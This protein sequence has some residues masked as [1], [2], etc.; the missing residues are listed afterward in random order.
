[1]NRHRGWR[2]TSSY[3]E[4]MEEG[5]VAR[6][7]HAFEQEP[8]PLL[9]RLRAWVGGKR[10]NVRVLCRCGHRGGIVE[11]ST[12]KMGW[13][14][15]NRAEG[16]EREKKRG[17]YEDEREGGKE[18]EGWEGKI[19]ESWMGEERKRKEQARAKGEG[20]QRTGEG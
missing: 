2:A 17:I 5:V 8:A 14:R 6:N 13:R 19:G 4:G 18:T 11:I 16:E 3:V 12:L 20:A 9:L 10:I 1:M 15:W 7:E